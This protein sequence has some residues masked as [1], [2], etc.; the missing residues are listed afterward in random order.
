MAVD[1]EQTRSPRLWLVMQGKEVS[2][3]RERVSVC[4]G[5]WSG[6]VVERKQSISHVQ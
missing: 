2:V 6:F 3:A 4:A 5:R 1:L